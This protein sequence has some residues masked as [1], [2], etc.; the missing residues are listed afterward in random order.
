MPGS[1]AVGK[2]IASEA[3]VT[4]PAPSYLFDFDFSNDVMAVVRPDK[5]FE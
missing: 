2:S 1:G 4:T 5:E 3:S